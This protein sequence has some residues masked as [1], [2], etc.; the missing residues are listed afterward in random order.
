[1][2]CI[3]LRFAPFDAR[4]GGGREQ[5]TEGQARTGQGEGQE[6]P[7]EATQ[8]GTRPLFPRLD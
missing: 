1:M 6:P 8:P 5:G 3:S 2:M 7:G 4:G